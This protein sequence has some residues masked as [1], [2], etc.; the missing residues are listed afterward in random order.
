ME[1]QFNNTKLKN[2]HS[3]L[4]TL[5]L[6]CTYIERKLWITCINLLEGAIIKKYKPA[7]EYY[8]LLGLCYLKMMIYNIAYY[9]YSQAILEE[10]NNLTSLFS[11]GKIYT[12]T[13]KKQQAVGV[14]SKILDI[15]H[16]N[17]IAQEAINILKK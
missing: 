4:N 15:D 11:I 2:E 17:K 16:N 1:S 14:Y 5:N 3:N 13:E 6:A 7:A 12:L 8:N 9:H 10:P